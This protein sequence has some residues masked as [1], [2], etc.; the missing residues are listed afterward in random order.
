MNLQHKYYSTQPYH[1]QIH[2]RSHKSHSAPTSTSTDIQYCI[3]TLNNILFVV[4]CSIP[5]SV[6]IKT[7]AQLKQQLLPL[8]YY[9]IDLIHN[10][11]VLSDSTLCNTVQ[12]KLLDQKYNILICVLNKHKYDTLQPILQHKL[13]KQFQHERTN[14]SSTGSNHQQ[15]NNITNMITTRYS[16]PKHNIVHITARYITPININT[17]AQDKLKS[18]SL[19]HT[20]FNELNRHSV[21][22]H[23]RD[24]ERLKFYDALNEE[25]SGEIHE[26]FDELI[27]LH[28]SDIDDMDS[29]DQQDD[30]YEYI[31][32]INE[33]KRSNQHDESDIEHDDDEEESSA[34]DDSADTSSH[35][36]DNIDSHD[37]DDDELID[38]EQH[39]HVE[40]ISHKEPNTGELLD[41]VH[42]EHNSSM[43]PILALS[44]NDTDIISSLINNTIDKQSNKKRRRDSMTSVNNNQPS[45]SSSPA[46]SSQHTSSITDTTDLNSVSS[47]IPPTTD[48]TNTP[49]T[50]TTSSSTTTSSSSNTN[51]IDNTLVR[52]LRDV[53]DD[54]DDDMYSFTVDEVAQQQLISMGFTS[55]SVE[56]ALTKFKNNIERST[57]YIVEHLNDSSIDQ[58][59]SINERNDLIA[60]HGTSIQSDLHHIL[61]Q[62]LQL[63]GYTE[64]ESIQAISRHG[65]NIDELYEHDSSSDEHHN[66]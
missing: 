48:N 61:L 18:S 17:T 19:L 3:L 6:H 25:H 8:P 22:H 23:N 47:V 36:S 59:M 65:I 27:P 4:H 44:S 62:Q 21:S 49:S 20:Q 33:F 54:G 29:L 13:Q 55:N 37:D 56:R 34:S 9:S 35:S 12:C 10:S 38:D 28:D 30:T 16:I 7:I 53:R 43:S 57:N 45:T 24:H 31:D 64:H 58:P 40:D 51:D 41:I 2:H 32:V 15:Y 14:K 50:S 46:L 66:Y 63:H 1:N 42:T 26:S 11:T 60:V 5:Q 39:N 52:L